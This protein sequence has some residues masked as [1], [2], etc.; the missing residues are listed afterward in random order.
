M[1]QS[2]LDAIKSRLQAAMPQADG[3]GDRVA[4]QALLEH[5]A[6]YESILSELK[7]TCPP[8]IEA[9]IDTCTE[10][11]QAWEKVEKALIKIICG[12]EDFS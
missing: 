6:E 8:D 7:R 1:T 2:Q 3:M 4:M 5:I 9:A 11:S 12:K 10:F